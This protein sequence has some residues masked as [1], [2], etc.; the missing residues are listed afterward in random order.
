MKRLRP[1]RANFVDAF[2]CNDVL[3]RRTKK[4]GGKFIITMAKKKANHLFVSVL[5]PSNEKNIAKFMTVL[6]LCER[7]FK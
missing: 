5:H 4:W 7:S 2:R 6:K 3:K 1:S